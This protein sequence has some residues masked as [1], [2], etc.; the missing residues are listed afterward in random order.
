[1]SSSVLA[2]EI[3]NDGRWLYA[4]DVEL[5]KPELG[6][7][8]PVKLLYRQDYALENMFKCD[9]AACSL[10]LPVELMM[11]YRSDHWFGFLDDIVPSG[12]SRRY[13]VEHLGIGNLPIGEQDSRLLAAGS[14]APVGNIRIR[15][16]LPE[17]LYGMAEKR[18]SF[19]DVA[20]R[21]VDFLEYAQEMGA[22]SGGATGAGGEAPKLLIR[23][24]PD[25]QVWIDTWQDDLTNLDQHYLVK[26]PRGRGTR[27]D[28]DILRAEF[29]FYHELSA[30]GVDT[31][32]TEKMM[33]HEGERFPS[34][35]LPRFD[36]AYTQGRVEHYAL[37]SVLSVL[38]Q[39]PGSFL[40][41]FAVVRGLVDVLLQESQASET[42]FDTETFVVE[43]L[44]RDLLNVI[45]ANS[46][47]HGRNTALIKRPQ[48]VWLSP[49]YDFA[50]MKADPEGVIRTMKWGAPFEQ[51]GEFKWHEIVRELE[52]LVCPGA[53]LDRM[54]CLAGRL[55]GLK[56][57]LKQRGVSE[58]LLEIPALGMNTTEARLQRWGLL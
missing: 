17:K 38:D 44:E 32:D 10:N 35:W 22:V 29:H 20:E 54:R 21:H 41:H 46:D 52:D 51:A 49:V 48:G 30:L 6:R 13:W 19:D 15:E 16:S 45:F 7:N 23:L 12:A 24:S 36:V 27:L 28:A 1:M 57:R 14:I 39:P 8:S 31:I 33:L 53:V 58:S 42:S 55:V 56:A 37:E 11:V 4:A 3:F 34:L 26:F 2:V 47:N 18:F 25:R 9:Q 40:N 5:L 50:P 43:W